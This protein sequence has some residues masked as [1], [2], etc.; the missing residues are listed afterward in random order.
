MKLCL[1]NCKNYNGY[2]DVLFMMRANDFRLQEPQFKI[3][4]EIL[5]PNPRRQLHRLYTNRGDFVINS[6]WSLSPVRP[7]HGPDG[8][9]KQL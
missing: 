8:R 2:K 6:D 1:V 3:N 7:I 5:D 9:L 4:Y